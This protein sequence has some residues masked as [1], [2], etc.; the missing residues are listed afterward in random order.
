MKARIDLVPA[1]CEFCGQ[2]LADES[3]KRRKGRI[4]T[5]EVVEQ[6]RGGLGAERYEPELGAGRGTPGLMVGARFQRP[7]GT[8]PHA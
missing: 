4:G 7:G 3:R 5:E 2:P 1:R 6:G 8:R